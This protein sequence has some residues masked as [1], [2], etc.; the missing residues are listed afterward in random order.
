M[1]RID[2]EKRREFLK[3]IEEMG[4]KRLKKVKKQDGSFEYE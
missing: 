2:E 3:L 1:P 4:R